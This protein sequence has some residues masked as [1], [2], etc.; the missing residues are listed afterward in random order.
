M[1]SL[2]F[3]IDISLP[4]ALGPWVWLSL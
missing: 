4:V 1:V 3:S 2:D